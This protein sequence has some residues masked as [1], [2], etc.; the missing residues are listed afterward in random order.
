MGLLGRIHTGFDGEISPQHQ[1]SKREALKEGGKNMPFA[2]QKENS[3]SVFV[4][5]VASR[6]GGRCLREGRRRKIQGYSKFGT[7]HF[8]FT[9]NLNMVYTVLLQAASTMGLM[10]QGFL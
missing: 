5:R 1:N 7:L 3:V 6:A 9:Q 4:Y 8:V 10:F 2:F